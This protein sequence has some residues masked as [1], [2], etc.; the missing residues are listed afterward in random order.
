MGG[1]GAAATSLTA[2]Q[3][4]VAGAKLQMFSATVGQVQDKF[5]QLGIHVPNPQ[6]DEHPPLQ[7]VVDVEDSPGPDPPLQAAADV[8]DNSEPDL[9]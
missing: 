3:L 4:H 7:A 5:C 2:A 9:T 8:A 6:N 1:L